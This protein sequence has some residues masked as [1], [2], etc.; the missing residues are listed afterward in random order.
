MKI[1]LSLVVITLITLSSAQAQTTFQLCSP[2]DTGCSPWVA[3]PTF[4]VNPFNGC[5]VDVAT[6]QR[7]CAGVPQFRIV[8]VTVIPDF[9]GRSNCGLVDIRAL[10]RMITL[11]LLQTQLAVDVPNCPDQTGIIVEVV[12]ATCIY[13]STCTL[14]YAS[15]PSSV[16]CDPPSQAGQYSGQNTITI[17]KHIPCGTSCCKKQYRLCRSYSAEL[18]TDYIS[19]EQL[20]TLTDACSAIPPGA[21]NS[22]IVICD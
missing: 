17:T 22:C 20:P 11:R 18:A 14:T 4:R 15:G 12:H 6:E 7:I 10:Y 2:P 8:S 16:V 5:V 9:T 1:L 19:I 3:L 21:A 13:E